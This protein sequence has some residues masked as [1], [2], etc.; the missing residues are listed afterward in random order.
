MLRAEFA[1]K[2]IQFYMKSPSTLYN[3]LKYHKDSKKY[4]HWY[5]VVSMIYEFFA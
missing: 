2:T 5:R 3:S 1:V 4:K